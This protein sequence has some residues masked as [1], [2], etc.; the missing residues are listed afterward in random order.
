MN[1]SFAKELDHEELVGLDRQRWV[2][3][4]TNKFKHRMGRKVWV[5]FI[6]KLSSFS[7]EVFGGGKITPEFVYYK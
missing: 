5:M 3:T 4:N 1:E 7:G 6:S 2:G